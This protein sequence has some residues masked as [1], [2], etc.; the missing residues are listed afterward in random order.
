MSCIEFDQI[1]VIE[2]SDFAPP[3]RAWAVVALRSSMTTG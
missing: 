3:S 2:C 1:A